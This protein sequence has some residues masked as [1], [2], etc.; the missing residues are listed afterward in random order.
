MPEAG[1]ISEERFMAATAGTTTSRIIVP[2]DGG[3]VAERALPVAVALARQA[4]LPV[5]LVTVLSDDDLDANAI[6]Y[7]KARTEELTGIDVH[8]DVIRGMPVV[9]PLVGYFHGHPGS[10]VVCSTHARLDTGTFRLGSVADELV[11]RS[12]APVVLVGPLT[13]LPDSGDRYEDVVVCV[14]DTTAHRLVRPVRDLTE[15][16]GLHPSLLQ[17][18]EPSY[19]SARVQDGAHQTALLQDLSAEFA[20]Q[21]ITVESDHVEDR[22]VPL[23]ITTHAQRRAA[24]LLALSSRRRYPEERYEES[25]VTVAIARIASCPVLVVGPAVRLPG[26]KTQGA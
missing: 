25:S 10:L 24:P 12:P 26:T 1:R 23:A 8:Y 18:A 17:V 19:G 15:T 9:D 13:H 3:P 4:G 2:L 11:R 20:E 14:E 21:G 6:V 5:S 16:L 22:N 7:L